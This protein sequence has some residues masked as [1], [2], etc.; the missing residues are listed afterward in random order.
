MSV[1]EV[2]TR[3]IAVQAVARRFEFDHLTHPDARQIAMS[4]ARTAQEMLMRIKRDDPEV[5]KG[6]SSLADARDAFIRAK[7]YTNGGG[8]G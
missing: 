5:T 7:I 6:L 8:E 4:F 3:H 2:S 1:L